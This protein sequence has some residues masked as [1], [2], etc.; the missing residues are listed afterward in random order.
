M[1]YGQATADLYMTSENMQCPLFFSLH[2]VDV[3]LGV[4]ALAH[5]WLPFLLYAFPPSNIPH[6]IQGEGFTINY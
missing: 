1:C 2:N 6:S 3:P 5:V 4:D